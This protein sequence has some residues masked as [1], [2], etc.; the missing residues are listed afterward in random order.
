[1]NKKFWDGLP[2]DVRETL[3]RAMAEATT[4]ANEIAQQEN[5]DALAA[6]KKSGTTTVHEQSAE[7]RAAWGKALE[8]VTRNL[9][10]R[11]GKEL[12]FEFY[13]EAHS[14]GTH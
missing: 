10:A 11:V 9:A 13:Q 8:P 7:E 6:I 4:Y 5:D 1:V 2:A 14:V 12:I 3:E